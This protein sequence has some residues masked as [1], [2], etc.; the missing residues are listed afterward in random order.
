[1][2]DERWRWTARRFSV[3]MENA[4]QEDATLQFNFYLHKAAT[5]RVRCGEQELP[6]VTYQAAGEQSYTAR[7]AVPQD[8]R[9]EFT[10]DH[11][12]GPTPE[13]PRELGVQ[14][15]FSGP[16]ALSIR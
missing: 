4:A 3:Q 12:I 15:D 13:D 5:L 11:G 6:P 2:E 1:L 7:L 9:L 14:V 8:A 16:A 10:L